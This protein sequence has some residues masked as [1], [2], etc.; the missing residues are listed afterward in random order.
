MS[1]IKCII[2]EDE[3][4]AVEILKGFLA[5]VSNWKIMASFDNA[6]DAIYYLSKNE[7]DVIFLD[8]QLPELNGIDFIKTLVNPPLIVI[9]SAYNE[10]AIEAF[11]LVV[12]DYLLKPY[13]FSR[14]VK[15]IAR[16]DNHFESDKNENAAPNDKFIY[17]K[18]NRKKIKVN[19]EDIVFIESQKEYV[20]IVCQ[21]NEVKTKLGITKVEN[22]F[23]SKLM[24]RVHRSFMVSKSKVT[25]YTNNQIVVIDYVIPIGKLYQ[26]DV[27]NQLDQVAKEL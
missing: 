18:E 23:S 3:Y 14:F 25:S 19:I 21:K 11:E 16:I 20:R 8:I 4:P 27:L 13:S 17:V 6:L 10:H 22:L 12:F 26:K 2:I 7:V 24:L 15:T 5:K 1:Y 9:T